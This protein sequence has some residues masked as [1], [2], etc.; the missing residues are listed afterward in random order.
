MTLSEVLITLMVLGIIAALTIPILNSKRPDKDA[1][2]FKKAFLNV[3]AAVAKLDEDMEYTE[4]CFN[5]KDNTGKLYETQEGFSCSGTI[6]SYRGVDG[7]SALQPYSNVTAI[8]F[9]KKLAEQL[10]T[11]GYNPDKT[12]KNPC[13]ETSSYSSPNFKTTDGL[14]YWG[15]EKAWSGTAGKKTITIK[16]DRQL[17]G[18]ELKRLKKL[19][20]DSY[21]KSNEESEG[22]S[23]VIDQFGGVSVPESPGYEAELLN[24]LMDVTK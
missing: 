15:L 23:I 2:M 8:N 13:E 1:V 3:S 5:K 21:Y 7:Q 9:C 11:S 17:S 10:N 22:L 4:F 6:T 14:R 12:T 20:G 16:V 18:S 19:R 24:K